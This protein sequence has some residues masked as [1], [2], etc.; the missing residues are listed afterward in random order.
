MSGYPLFIGHWSR[1]RTGQ[2]RSYSELVKIGGY[3]LHKWRR[4]MSKL[5][6]LVV[7][8]AAALLVPVDQ[9]QTKKLSVQIVNRQSSATEYSYTVPGYVASSCNASVYGNIAT[10]NCVATGIPASSG[11]YSVH[12]ATLSLLIPDG[13]IVVNDDGGT[14]RSFAVGPFLVPASKS[15]AT[16]QP[17]RW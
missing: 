1:P 7:A 6:I 4:P 8:L 13:R 2:C 5:L 16:C 12:G 3:C 17:R 11:S 15:I 9:A 10:G 14:S